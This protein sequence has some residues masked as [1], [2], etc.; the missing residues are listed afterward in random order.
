M[1]VAILEAPNGQW[2]GRPADTGAGHPGI[3]TAPKEPGV[4]I[5]FNNRRSINV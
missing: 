4:Q 3:T 2:P 1:R 5:N